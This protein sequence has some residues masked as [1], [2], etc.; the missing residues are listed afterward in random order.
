M[1]NII[2]LFLL[3]IICWISVYCE[4]KINKSKYLSTEEELNYPKIKNV[5]IILKRY[6]PIII[7][8]FTFISTQVIELVEYKFAKAICYL[9]GV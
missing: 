2:K 4:T 6:F 3:S 8:F 9:F 5:F 7:V 1:E